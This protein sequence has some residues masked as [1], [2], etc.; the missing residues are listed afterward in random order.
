[1]SHVDVCLVLY[2][3]MGP[4]Q[5]CRAFFLVLLFP[6]AT[7]STSNDEFVR[8]LGFYDKARKLEY[9]TCNVL[10]RTCALIRQAGTRPQNRANRKYPPNNKLLTTVAVK[11]LQTKK[12]QLEHANRVTSAVPIVHT[13]CTEEA[14]YGRT[15][16]T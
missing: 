10:N 9:K 12:N 16:E 8:L 14:L 2:V 3:G 5:P 1:M 7:K 13:G 4:D 6:V 11:I 15:L